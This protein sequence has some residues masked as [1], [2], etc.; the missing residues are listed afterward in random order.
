MAR[1]DV[2]VD[3][4][5]WLEVWE[6]NTNRTED[7]GTS[8]SRLGNKA[9]ISSIT[10]DASHGRSK[11]PSSGFIQPLFCWLPTLFLT[12]LMLLPLDVAAQTLIVGPAEYYLSHYEDS[13]GNVTENAY[14]IGVPD[15]VAR[16]FRIK[17]ISRKRSVY[18]DSDGRRY[19]CAEYPKYTA[20]GGTIAFTVDDG[21]TQCEGTAGFFFTIKKR[22]TVDA[23]F[24]DEIYCDDGTFI[25]IQYVGRAPARVSR[26]A[27]ARR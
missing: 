27:G 5:S 10:G 12:V 11:R 9:R 15:V 26:P 14:A 2:L 25:R 6:P 16:S 13:A 22:N 7:E 17:L 20:C 19:S 1:S 8:R 4:L 24:Q 3:A 18:S 21:L 23:I